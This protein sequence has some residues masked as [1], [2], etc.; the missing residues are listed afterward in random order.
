[1]EGIL[2]QSNSAQEDAPKIEVEEYF[3]G[4]IP[5]NF[6]V[7]PIGYI[8]REGKNIKNGDKKV[9]ENDV[10]IEDPTAVKD[11]PVWKNEQGADLLT[12]AKIVNTN[13]AMVS[14]S[15][16]PFYEYEVLKY[17]MSIFKFNV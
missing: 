13:K 5:A 4:Y 2:E 6:T 12:V 17:L 11:L 14:K 8:E 15:G 1:M 3:T 16:D 9:D 7:D 10:T